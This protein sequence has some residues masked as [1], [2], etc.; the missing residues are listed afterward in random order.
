MISDCS[1]LG[2][3]GFGLTIVFLVVLAYFL[4]VLAGSKK[5][6]LEDER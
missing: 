4:G 6:L 5:K 3:F 1:A 2:G